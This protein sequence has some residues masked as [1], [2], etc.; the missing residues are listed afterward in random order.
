LYRYRPESH[1]W[2]GKF[3]ISGFASGVGTSSRAYTVTFR[4]KDYY[5]K[6]ISESESTVSFLHT[7][8]EALSA[9]D[10]L[11]SCV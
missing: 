7:F 11:D 4:L 9:Y 3:S 2:Q 1:T 8:S 10:T 5:G 6:S